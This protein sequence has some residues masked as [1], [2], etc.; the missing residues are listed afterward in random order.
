MCVCVCVCVWGGGGGGTGWDGEGI[1]SKL[2][3]VGNNLLLTSWGLHSGW[4]DFF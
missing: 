2:V 4:L 1:S 3:M